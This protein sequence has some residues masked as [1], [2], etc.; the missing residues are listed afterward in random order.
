M[1]GERVLLC[2]DEPAVLEVFGRVLRTGG[3]D[4]LTARDGQEGV[5]IALRER[6]DLVLMDMQMPVMRGLEATRRI[7]AEA[8][9]MVVI[10]F[11]G[12]ADNDE[13][14]TGLAAGCDGVIRKPTN[15]QQLV[16]Q[17]RLCLEEGD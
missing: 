9:E 2:D 11:T 7:K 12:H 15:P 10:A 13:L 1:S 3:Y 4:V 6:P 14:H 16:E 8:P 5:E 17:V